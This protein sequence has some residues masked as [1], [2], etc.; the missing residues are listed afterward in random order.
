MAL[1][2]ILYQAASEII[3]RY[4]PDA[5]EYADNMLRCCLGK[6]DRRAADVWLALGN[7]I[8]DLTRLAAG[9]TRH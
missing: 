4:G 2:T 6:G 7:A 5:E 1:P 3:E 9:Q 8:E